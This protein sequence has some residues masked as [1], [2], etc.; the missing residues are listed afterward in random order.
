MGD[1]RCRPSRVLT[2]AASPPPLSGMVPRTSSTFPT[3]LPLPLPTML[4]MSVALCQDVDPHR[5]AWVH[6]TGHLCCRLTSSTNHGSNSALAFLRPLWPAA[7]AVAVVPVAGVHEQYH[8]PGKPLKAGGVV[9]QV[10]P[11]RAPP[12]CQ[13]APCGGVTT[14]A[15]AATI[16]W[17]GGQGP[18][19]KCQQHSHRSVC[20]M[21][22]APALLDRPLPACC[23]GSK[24]GKGDGRDN[25]GDTGGGG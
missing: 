17:W 4:L 18:L 9:D 22:K 15:A 13:G 21:L 6:P 19:H 23:A 24:D 11:A 16:S 3:L 25:D 14:A 1:C 2:M 10:D 5:H 8:H 12:V 7:I 20:L